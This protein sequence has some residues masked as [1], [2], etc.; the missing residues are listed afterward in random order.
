MV[1]LVNKVF[2]EKANKCVVVCGWTESI[3]MEGRCQW[4]Y[5]KNWHCNRKG[6]WENI[7]FVLIHKSS[8]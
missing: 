4:Y 6:N 7:K 2:E 1:M 8:V 3:G 5:S